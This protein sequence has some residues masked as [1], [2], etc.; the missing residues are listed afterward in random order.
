[1]CYLSLQLKKIL[2]VCSVVLLSGCG[3]TTEERPFVPPVYPAAPDDP[4]FIYERSLMGS[5]DVEE[6]TSEQKFKAMATGVP[7]GER[8]LVKPFD[9]AVRKGRVYI[10]DTVSRQVVLFN[11][12]DSKFVEF[13]NKGPGR[14]SK[15]IGI[16]VGPTGEV[17]VVDNSA[18]RVMVY[19]KD[20]Q[21]LRSFGGKDELSRPADVAISND[22]QY[23]YVVDT[24]G[25]QSR[26]HR[27]QKY[28]AQSGEL[29]NAIGTRGL[30]L[31]EFN[32]PMMIDIDSKDRIYVLDSGNFRVQRFNADGEFELAFGKVGNRLGDFSRPKGLAIDAEDNIYVMDSSFANFQIFNEKGELLLFV[33]Q[34]S[35]NNEPG[36]FSLP[37][38]IAVD[39]DGRIY[40]VDQFF[41]KVEVFRPYGMKQSE[42][43]AGVAPVKQ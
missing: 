7:V 30:A 17:F 14:L 3:A 27:V 35:V 12:H 8:G 13:G 38:G 22:G 41:S 16:T 32:L 29:L 11:I 33:G 28:D 1:M 25:V 2:L 23:A 4:R 37:A 9:V 21:F 43:Y 36:M 5:A 42:G 40:A 31:G 26:D 18:K 20:G 6:L 24:G 19:D 34:R 15:P 10:T 39:E